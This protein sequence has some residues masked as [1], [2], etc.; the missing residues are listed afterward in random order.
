MTIDKF[1]Q[2]TNNEAKHVVVSENLKKRMLENN[3]LGVF[4]SY[5]AKKWSTFLDTNITWAYLKQRGKVDDG[6]HTSRNNY[7]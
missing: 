2:N 1:Q 7:M 6:R 5:K 3:L 4:K